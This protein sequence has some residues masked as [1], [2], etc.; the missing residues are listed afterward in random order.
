MNTRFAAIA[1][2]LLV[3][4]SLFVTS[5]ISQNLTNSALTTTSQAAGTSCA[6]SATCSNCPDGTCGGA[7][8]VSCAD[9]KKLNI[10]CNYIDESG[11]PVVVTAPTDI[12][13][14]ISACLFANVCSGRA[15]A[16]KAGYNIRGFDASNY[17]KWC[18]SFCDGTS[19]V[20]PSVNPSLTLSPSV[21][22]SIAP[23]QGCPLPLIPGGNVCT[24]SS[25]GRDCCAAGHYCHEQFKI[26]VNASQ[27]S[28]TPGSR[29]VCLMP[30]DPQRNGTK[31]G[32]NNPGFPNG[33]PCCDGRKC[34]VS[35]VNNPG[36]DE[37]YDIECEDTITPSVTPI[38][39]IAAGACSDSCLPSKGCRSGQGTCGNVDDPTKPPS[40]EFC[41][42]NPGKCKCIINKA[43]T[44]GS[45]D[46]DC[47]CLDV[48][49][50][51]GIGANGPKGARCGKVCDPDDP[52]DCFEYPQCKPGLKC[53]LYPDEEFGRCKNGYCPT[54]TPKATPPWFYNAPRESTQTIQLRREAEIQ[55]LLR[56]NPN[57]TREMLLNLPYGV[58]VDLGIN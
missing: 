40:E 49:N 3:G 11:N 6:L 32:C 4:I 45:T 5:L 19:T 50:C 31:F 22:P 35:R 13:P 30:E 53:D 57:F 20:S 58:R 14:P 2:T 12:Q 56:E 8:Q 23:G 15:G 43:C 41:S 42:R 33:N 54:P 44:P 28:P 25:S 24:P 21:A 47:W 10:N 34:R 36:D 16:I 52:T 1:G 27:I 55:S 9:G 7:D 51:P 39:T 29:P 38:P 48:N 46:N 37:T 18:K 17:R 26:C